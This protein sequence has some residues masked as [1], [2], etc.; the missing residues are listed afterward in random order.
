MKN[1]NNN[2][3]LNNFSV[4]NHKIR[5]FA[6]PVMDLYQCKAVVMLGKRIVFRRQVSQASS[7]IGVDEVFKSVLL[8]RACGPMNVTDQGIT[9]CLVECGL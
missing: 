5:N 1:V 4:F 9:E 6:F 2:A 3:K 8:C 7:R